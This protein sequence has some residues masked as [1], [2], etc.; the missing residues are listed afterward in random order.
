VDKAGDG[1]LQN[2]HHT[3]VPGVLGHLE[4]ELLRSGRDLLPADL[5]DD[6]V[7]QLAGALI[8]EAVASHLGTRVSEAL[9]Q[10]N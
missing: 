1:V 10:L 4:G 3:L 5:A 8:K 2:A 9:S 6:S 7:G